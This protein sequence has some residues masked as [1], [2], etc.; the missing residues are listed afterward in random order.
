M[1]SKTSLA[2]EDL[3]WWQP[4]KYKIIDQ[5]NGMRLI[6]FSSK[7][8]LRKVAKDFFGREARVLENKI[9]RVQFSDCKTDYQDFEVVPYNGKR[10]LLIQASDK[11]WIARWAVNIHLEYRWLKEAFPESFKPTC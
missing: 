6:L 7:R 11:N 8:S 10:A 2:P 4:K 3:W 9:I 5:E 1:K